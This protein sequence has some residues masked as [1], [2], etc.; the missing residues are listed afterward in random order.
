[1]KLHVIM[2]KIKCV[3]WLP[4]HYNC[5][6]DS[7]LLHSFLLIYHSY[8]LHEMI[9]YLY[10]CQEG[11]KSKVSYEWTLLFNV[12][13]LYFYLSVYF[14]THNI[15]ITSIKIISNERGSR[16]GKL[17]KMIATRHCH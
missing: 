16:D 8:P 11:A 12:Y 14:T 7:F 9:L 2:M 17:V 5:T 4:I 15:I 10:I 13:I 1:M 6:G 3:S